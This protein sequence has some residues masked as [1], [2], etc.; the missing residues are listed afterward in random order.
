[1]ERGLEARE[2]TADSKLR[3]KRLAL[4]QAK[5][6]ERIMQAK[7]AIEQGSFEKAKRQLQELVQDA[8][9]ERMVAEGLHDQ[10]QQPWPLEPQDGHEL[11]RR[12]DRLADTSLGKGRVGGIGQ[13]GNPAHFAGL[14]DM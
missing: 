4:E 7:I 14:L 6:A 11:Q 2:V 13:S 1:M 9:G 5:E 12:L 3:Q 10:Y 8:A